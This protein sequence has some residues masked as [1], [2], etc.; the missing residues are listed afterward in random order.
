MTVS[1]LPRLVARPSG[2]GRAA[3]RPVLVLFTRAPLEE[4]RAKR[5]PAEAG[6]AVLATFLLGWQETADAVGADLLVVS[7]RTS[8]AGL[9]RLLPRSSAVPQMGPTFGTRIAAAIDAGFARGASAVLLVGGDTPPLPAATV[10]AAF[11]SLEAAEDRLVVAPAADGGVA[12]LGFAERPA[13]ALF[14]VPWC[15]SRLRWAL[16][17][18][19]IRLGLEVMRVAGAPDLDGTSHLD[20]LALWLRAAR[21]AGQALLARVVAALLAALRHLPR[22]ASLMVP[23]ALR[24]SARSARA[25]PIPA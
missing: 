21:P 16:E 19:A 23:F 10:E 9:R 25:P 17:N 2:P 3:P 13:Q 15:T 7:P 24:R 1:R 6:A 12:A 22:P 14:S 11:R 4:A 8:M 5:L 18:Q 20:G